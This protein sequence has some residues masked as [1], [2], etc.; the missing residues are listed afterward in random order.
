MRKFLLL[1]LPAIAFSLQSQTKLVSSVEEEYDGS[2]WVIT[3]GTDYEYDNNNNLT[4]EIYYNWNGTAWVDEYK[5]TRTYDINNKVVE[6][7]IYM[8]D[9][10]SQ[11]DSVEKTVFTYNSLGLVIQ[12]NE[13]LWDGT[14]W[15]KSKKDYIYDN[16]KMSKIEESHYDGTQF[17]LSER[18]TLTYIGNYLSEKLLEWNNGIQW[19]TSSRY[20]FTY[21]SNNKLENRKFETYDGSNWTELVVVNYELDASF[22][23]LRE[24]YNVEGINAGKLEYEY[25]LSAQMSSFAHPFKDNSGLDYLLEDF[26][27]VNKILSSTSFDYDVPSATY[28]ATERIT[29]NYNNHIVLNTEDFKEIQNIV[30]YPNPANDYLQITGITKSETIAVYDMLGVKAFELVVKENDQVNIQNLSKGMYLM[31]FENGNTLKFL[32]K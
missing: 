21:D 5:E 24:S 30:L 22:N 14:Q 3:Y 19:I 12:S 31:K 4:T 18:K 26:P 27:Y 1:M 2:S 6:E 25:D 29:Y 32:K 20:L 11:Y 13:Y 9:G 23:R 7:V 10:I 17:I 16:N 8:W 28:N 15:V